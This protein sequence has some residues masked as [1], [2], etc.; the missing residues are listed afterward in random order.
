MNNYSPNVIVHIASLE[1]EVV[2][3]FSLLAWS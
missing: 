1:L 2:W 3:V